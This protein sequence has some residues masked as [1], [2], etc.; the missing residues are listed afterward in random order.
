MANA[1]ISKVYLINTPLENDYK[2]TLYFD[3]AS[4]Q[5]SYF[6]SKVVESFMNVSYQRKDYKMRIPKHIDKLAKCN[7]V[8]YQ[9]TFY[10]NKW[11]YA[12]ITKKE[13]I[14]EGVTEIT[15][16]TDVMQTFM[17]DYEVKTSFVEREHVK[18][19]AIGLHTI[20]EGLETGEYICNEVETI[21]NGSFCYVLGFTRD[22]ND[23][24]KKVG[25]KI[26]NGIY[27]G[28]KYL[29]FFST[30]ELSD[31]IA[32]IDSQG[33]GE[34]ITTIF[35]IPKNLIGNPTKES[36]DLFYEIPESVGAT[37]CESFLIARL[38]ELD[39]YTP[40]N[41]KL[42]A[43]PY[44]YLLVDNCSGSSAEYRYEHFRNPLQCK[45]VIRG[46][47]TPGTSRIL[48]PDNYLEG[49]NDSE[50]FPDYTLNHGLTLGKYPICNWT[51]D[52][53]TNWLTQNSVNNAV[54]Y[55]SAG[56]QMA[57][58]VAAIATGAGAVAGASM[59]ANG[60]IQIASVMGTKYQ[61][62]FSPM[63]SKGNLNCG[64]VITS[65]HMN[66]PVFYKMSIKKEYAKVLDQYFNM[67]GYQVNS[68]KVPNKNHRANYWYTKTID[69]NID[70]AIPMED[71][72][73]IKN[74]Y[75]N[76]ITFWRVPSNIQNYSV[77]NSIV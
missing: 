14:S 77:N 9:N 53:Y 73:I 34:D 67:F 26:Y 56:L 64:D 38:S 35:V 32:D 13:F 60:G 23:L 24:S 28:V 61:Q 74:C 51:S 36:S 63:Q 45:F 37:L 20:P 7:Y 57:G 19:D 66:M 40:T 62:S 8:M 16:E 58:G 6:Q 76:G 39:T 68:V 70:G 59:I 42:L 47:L 4:S 21:E 50:L 22:Y 41:K 49:N 44:Q 43:Y 10:T 69:V 25:G 55:A 54:G 29:A 71:M 27:S 5:H 11:F 52:S 65:M 75:N 18:D 48:I 46:S 30:A 1:N 15:I 12:F 72:Q 2:N 33:Y 17:F 3:S 31:F